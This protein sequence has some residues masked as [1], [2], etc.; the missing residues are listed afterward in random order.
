MLR[1]ISYVLKKGEKLKQW[2]VLTLYPGVQVSIKREFIQTI[3]NKASP[4][5]CPLRCL[6]LIRTV[7]VVHGVRLY[8]LYT[9]DQIMQNTTGFVTII[10]LYYN[11]IYCTCSLDK[12]R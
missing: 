2:Q 7:S 11:N 12:I 4:S 5:Q 8:N 3:D 1:K 10:Q 6:F 9:D